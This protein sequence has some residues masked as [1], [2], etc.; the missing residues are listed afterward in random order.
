M[1]PVFQTRGGAAFAKITAAGDKVVVRG[2]NC[3]QAAL[4]SLFGMPLDD[5]PDFVNDLWLDDQWFRH[6]QTWCVDKRRRM[7]LWLGFDAS[8]SLYDLDALPWKPAGYSLIT[9]KSKRGHAHVCV[10]LDGKIVH[11]PWRDPETGELGDGLV[12]VDGWYVLL[13]VAH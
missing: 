5:V 10:A 8:S 4:A 12:A 7:I 6:V 9:G 11:D 2:G 1:T 13:P 3:F